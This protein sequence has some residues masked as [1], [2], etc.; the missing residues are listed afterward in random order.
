M[1]PTLAQ[2][3]RAVN[4]RFARL[5]VNV[6]LV[7]TDEDDVFMAR[8]KAIRARDNGF[9]CTINPGVVRFVRSI[10]GRLS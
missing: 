1:T 9:N 6:G 2:A 5:D 8:G 4:L 7:G 10:P 3:Q